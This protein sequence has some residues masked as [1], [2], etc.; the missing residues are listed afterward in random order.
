MGVLIMKIKRDMCIDERWMNAALDEAHSAFLEGEVPIGAVIVVDDQIVGRG[1][2]RR[3]IDNDPLAHAEM[4]ALQDAA[5]T[6]KNWR[7]D[8]ATMYVTLEPCP[9]CAGALTQ[10]R[11]KRLVFA[12]H[13]PKTGAVRSVYQLC[14][15]PRAPHRLAVRSGVCKEESAALLRKFF[16]RR[17]KDSTQTAET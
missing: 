5:R 13:E 12:A 7:L 10:A 16:E 15:D 2:N 8:D 4:Q 3:V 17:R 14:D 11:V 1:H 6:L 9:M